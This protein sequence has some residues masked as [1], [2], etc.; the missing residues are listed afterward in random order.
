MDVKLGIIIPTRGDR[1]RFLNNCLSQISRQS[2][3]NIP[4][5]PDPLI[6]VVDFEPKPEVIDITKRYRLGYETFKN[7]GLDLIAFIEDDECYSPIY[8]EFMIRSWIESGKTDL[9]G[10]T[11]TFYL[12]LRLMRYFT[13]NHVQRSSMMNTFIRPDLNFEWCPDETAYTDMHLWDNCKQLSR[14]LI[15]PDPPIAI[16]IKHGE[17]MC[18]GFAH[19]NGM[20]N[21]TG[22]R[23]HEDGGLLR[24]V[25]DDESFEFFSRYFEL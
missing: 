23:G 19:T 2:I 15:T 9:F 13:M 24:S 16:G 1:K 11:Y 7:K 18:G 25:C 8:L 4:D 12:H 20:D 17:G 10:T 6:L 21:Y 14:A 5:F 3:Y 22:P